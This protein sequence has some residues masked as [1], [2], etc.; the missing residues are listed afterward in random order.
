MQKYD[1]SLIYTIV[2]K[3]FLTNLKLFEQ[4]EKPILNKRKIQENILEKAQKKNSV[5]LQRNLKLEYFIY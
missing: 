3:K 4:I 5:P 2:I 1:K